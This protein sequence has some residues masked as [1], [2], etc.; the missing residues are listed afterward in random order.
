VLDAA[1]VLGELARWEW[2]PAELEVVWSDNMFRMFGL[3]PGALRPT[4]EYVVA[5]THPADRDRV[6]EAIA[7][8]GATG[9]FVQ[10]DFRFV[11]PDG[12]VRHLRAIPSVD[13]WREGRP[14]RMIGWVRDMSAERSASREVAAHVAVTEALAACDSIRGAGPR[15]LE[16]LGRTMDFDAGVLWVRRAE[17]LVPEATWSA[18]GVPWG[19]FAAITNR[20]RLRRGVDLP[21]LAWTAGRPVTSAAR[22]GG[23]GGAGEAGVG[24]GE[25]GAGVG[26]GVG[27]VSAGRRARAA[28]RVGLLGRVAFPTVSAGQVLAVV[29]LLSRE[30]VT[31]TGQLARSLSAIGYEIGHFA[32]SWTAEPTGAA[33]TP[34]QVEVLG[35]AARGIPARASAEQL[36][37]APAT[38]LAHLAN[39][40]ERLRVT[41]KKAAVAEAR[42]LGLLD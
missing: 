30:P 10:V 17:R 22:A 26:V 20:A 14:H 42:R 8:L 31:V 27:S 28:A 23:A 24:T 39:I 13:E 18:A 12:A 7:V 32:A 35:C 5:H 40:Y 34:R 2:T 21:G 3:Q 15:L 29:E 1:E 37:V 25:A 16:A 11:R 4:I 41:D 36:G 6:G 33:L 19:D 38:V 9:A